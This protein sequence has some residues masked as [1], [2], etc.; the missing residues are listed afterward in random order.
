MILNMIEVTSLV[1]CMDYHHAYFSS[2]ADGIIIGPDVLAGDGVVMPD[3]TAA[4]HRQGLYVQAT[5]KVSYVSVV[6]CSPTDYREDICWII[7]ILTK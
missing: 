2:S 6:T 7:I 1:L 4:S 5:L 3:T